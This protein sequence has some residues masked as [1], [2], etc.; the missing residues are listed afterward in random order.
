MSE[1][2]F[3]VFS[4]ESRAPIKV[5]RYEHRANA[6]ASNCRDEAYVEDAEFEASVPLPS[7]GEI[8]EAME[9][10]A[11]HPTP[12]DLVACAVNLADIYQMSAIRRCDFMLHLVDG[13][14]IEVKGN[15]I[16]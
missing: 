9:V 3:I 14:T 8:E 16:R 6:F 2:C 13:R 11:R 15:N 4:R 7:K 1:T 12:T 5:F 10:L